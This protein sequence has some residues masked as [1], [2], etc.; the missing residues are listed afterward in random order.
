[1]RNGA[2][3]FSVGGGGGD[4]VDSA[5][6]KMGF[7]AP[8]IDKDDLGGSLEKEMKKIKKVADKHWPYDGRGESKDEAEKKSM[9]DFINV[10]AKEVKKMEGG[11]DGA[12]D[13]FLKVCRMLYYQVNDPDES[14][15]TKITIEPKQITNGSLN[16]VISGGIFMLKLLE[17][18]NKSDELKNAGAKNLIKY[19]ICVC[20]HWNAIIKKIDGLAG[21]G[22]DDDGG[23]NKKKK[24]SKKDDEDGGDGEEEDKPKKKK[25]TSKKKDEDAEDDE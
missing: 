15:R 16:D 14:K 19:L 9:G 25:K 3:G 18:V 7:T 8:K 1:M 21:G 11:G 6:A 5:C 17:N 24:K 23:G 13:N 4:K 10:Y 12:A 2:E 20:K 22:G